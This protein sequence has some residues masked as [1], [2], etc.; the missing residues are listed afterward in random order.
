MPAQPVLVLKRD[1]FNGRKVVKIHFKYDR[2][3]IKILRGIPGTFWSPEHKC[4]IMPESHFRF[5]QLIKEAGMIACIKDEVK[6][7]EIEL[8][9]GYLERLKRKNYSPNTIKIYVSYMKDFM[10]EFRGAN[11]RNISP[12]QINSYM[13]KLIQEKTISTSQQ[14]QRINAIKFYYEQVLGLKKN[15]YRVDRPRKTK[16]LPKVLSEPEVLAMLDSTTN[17]KHKAILATLYSAGLRR[18]ELIGLRKHDLDFNRHLIM[19]RGGKGKKDRITILSST[20]ASLVKNYLLIY[21]PNYWLFEGVNRKQYS[22]TSIARIVE[23]AALRAGLDRKVS[24]HM[25]RHSFATHML[26]QGTDIRYIQAILGHGSSKTT[27]IYTHVSRSSLASIRSP[28]DVILHK[29]D[30]R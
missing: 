18:S 13:L 29:R 20:L 9:D 25:L 21:S 10:V 16:M 15:Y 6:K 17:I 1:M 2:R 14:N 22:P 30:K 23:K 26:E 27:E 7:P 3:I 28:L 8:P 5:Q 24:P 12:E 19:I 4:W 11:L